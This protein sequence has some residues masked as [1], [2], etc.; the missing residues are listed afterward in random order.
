MLVEHIMRR[1]VFTIHHDRT[2]LNACNIFKKFKVGCLVVVD[3]HNSHVGILTERDVIE[4]AIC[5]GKRPEETKVEEVMTEDV[6]TIHPLLKVDEAIEM[7]KEFH[8]KKLLVVL[9]GTIVGIITITDISFA[10]PERTTEFI[11]T[12]VKS[13]WVD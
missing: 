12:W 11:D 4:R 1:R 7:M 6:K 10:R 5:E 2:V 13:R 8:I 9:D 3:R